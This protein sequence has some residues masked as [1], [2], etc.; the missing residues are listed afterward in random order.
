MWVTRESFETG[1]KRTAK[2]E[3]ELQSKIEQI[4]RL[5]KEIDYWRDKF[6]SAQNRADRIADKSLAVSGI[7]PV[8]DLG[9]KELDETMGR[10]A[11]MAKD[12]ERQT[13][14]MFGEEIPMDGTENS[15]LVIDPKLIA[16]LADGL[17][18]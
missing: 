9:M 4:S 16:A 18:E 7:G 13:T 11:K 12:T 3:V 10:Y 14:E 1:L 17:R 15:E 6:E 5:E 2:L 8:S